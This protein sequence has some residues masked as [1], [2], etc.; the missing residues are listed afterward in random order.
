MILNDCRLVY[1]FSCSGSRRIGVTHSGE[2]GEAK[3]HTVLR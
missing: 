3:Q 2:L 1:L